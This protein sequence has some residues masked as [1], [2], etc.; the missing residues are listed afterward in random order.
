MW[1]SRTAAISA[2]PSTATAKR[3]WIK[4]KPGYCLTPQK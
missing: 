2:K 3:N 4:S 1:S